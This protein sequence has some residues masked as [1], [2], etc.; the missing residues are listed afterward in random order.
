MPARQS[1]RGIS[2]A[3]PLIQQT[4]AQSL[5]MWTALVASAIREGQA[6]GS[7]VPELNADEVARFMINSWEGAVVRMKLANGR[8]PLD[9][10]FAVAF[11]LLGHPSS[12]QP[13]PKRSSIG[14]V[15]G[16]SRGASESKLSAA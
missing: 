1:R 9:D 16:R 7:I 4:I 6:G 10:F 15:S 13:A 11:R 8:Q 12:A 14:P 3:A 2:G 5:T